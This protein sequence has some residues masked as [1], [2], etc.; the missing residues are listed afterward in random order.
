M[1]AFGPSLIWIRMVK[2][3]VLSVT[4]FAQPD[5]QMR[6]MEKMIHKYIWGFKEAIIAPLWDK[7]M[8][9]LFQGELFP[10]NPLMGII[11]R[12]S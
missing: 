11:L 3:T 1:T 7:D 10:L 5:V 4:V 8:L 12:I 6:R 9:F 2:V